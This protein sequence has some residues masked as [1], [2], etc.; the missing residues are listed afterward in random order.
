MKKNFYLQIK[1][2]NSRQL[3][4]QHVFASAAQV[5]TCESADRCGYGIGY[6]ESAAVN[7][8]SETLGK[9]IVKY[10]QYIISQQFMTEEEGEK[11]SSWAVTLSSG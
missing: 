11:R 10:I 3:L 8:A 5:A 6:W 1:Q 2:D 9:N 7:H 4:I